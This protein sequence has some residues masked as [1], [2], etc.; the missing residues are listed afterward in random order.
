MFKSTDVALWGV[1]LLWIRGQNHQPNDSPF[2]QT[3]SHDCT[4]KA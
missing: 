4:A 3:E 2:R 1:Q